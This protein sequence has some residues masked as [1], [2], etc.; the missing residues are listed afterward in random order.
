VKILARFILFNIYVLTIAIVY[1]A[2]LF[3]RKKKVH[4]RVVI[5]GTFHNP[6]WFHAH[7]EPIVTSG[8][9]EIILV[10]DERLADLPNLTYECPPVWLSKTIT[11]AGAKFLWTILVGI[12]APSD[13]FVGY[14]IFPSAITALIASSLCGA[15]SCYQVTSGPLELKGGGYAAENRLLAS[16]KQP[17]KLIEYLANKII[18]QCDLV[19]VRGSEA[20]DYITA[21]GFTNKLE[22]VTGSVLTDQRYIAQSRDIDVI[23][24]GRLAEYKRP[25]MFVSVIAALREKMP[26]I[27]VKMAGDGPMMIELKNQIEKL[28]LEDTIEMLG[29]RKDIPELFGRSKTLVLTSRWEGVSIAMLEGMALG[30]VPVVVNTGDLKDFVKNQE[31]GFISNSGNVEEISQ[32]LL[33]V[34]SDTQ[35]RS[36]LAD[37]ARQIVKKKC[38]R[39]ILAKRWKD[40][41][42]DTVMPQHKKSSTT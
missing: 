18:R 25:D 27:K 29:I 36:R 8:Y 3:G 14:H 24:V 39:S 30:V 2:R 7:I 32:N 42:E 21:A 17:S 19:V 12:R 26:G 11:R 5:N 9:G 35:L 10:T 38:D 37:N 33:S 22:V 40:I 4:R 23:F 13:L 34:L 41:I 31:T 15:R 28:G 20:A 16:L 1:I 6:N